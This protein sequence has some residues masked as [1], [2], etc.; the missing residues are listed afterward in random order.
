MRIDMNMKIEIDIFTGFLGSG[1]TYFIDKLLEK[2]L[3]SGEKVIIIQCEAGEKSIDPSKYK[4]GKVLLKE[5]DPSKPL[6]KAYLKQ[7]IHFYNPHKIVIEHNGMRMLSETLSLFNDEELEKLCLEPVVYHTADTITFNMFLSN[8]RELI[9]P[10]IYH[11]NLVVL[12]NY[13]SIDSLE[14]NKLLKK[15]KDIN[16]DAVIIPIRNLDE[17]Y[18][19]LNKAEVLADGV[20]KSFKITFNNIIKRK[21]K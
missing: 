7:M 17:L 12:N 5:Y 6:T 13:N 14:R 4:K 20:I 8:M 16:Y 10:F 18:G 1:K 3:V 2:T 11:S 15:I 21:K 9:E 19:A